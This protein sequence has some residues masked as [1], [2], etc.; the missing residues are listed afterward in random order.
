MPGL[1]PPDASKPYPTPA[2]PKGWKISE[3]LPYYSPALSGGGVSENMFKDLMAQGGQLPPG[4]PDMSAMAAMMGGG[5]GDSGGG[6]GEPSKK[7]KEKKK[8][9]RA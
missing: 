3:I 5:G 1:P 2:V 4:M 8:I 7:K 6:G 9:I